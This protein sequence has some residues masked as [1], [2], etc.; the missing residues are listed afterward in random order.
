MAWVSGISVH[1]VAQQLRAVAAGAAPP[2]PTTPEAGEDE[3]EEGR[4]LFRR[5][6]E[7]ERDRR[8][9]R[10]KKQAA[11]DGCVTCPARP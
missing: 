6:R 8:L 4:I 10:A 9:V 2:P 1:R 11:V 5:H 3:S 7:R